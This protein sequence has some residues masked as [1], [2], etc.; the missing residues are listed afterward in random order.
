MENDNILKEQVPTLDELVEMETRKYEHKIQ[1]L[2]FKMVNLE[3]ENNH[4][5]ERL[6]EQEYHFFYILG[7]LTYNFY[8]EDK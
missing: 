8:K 5:K 2:S 1:D 3:T 7:K 6:I 4:L